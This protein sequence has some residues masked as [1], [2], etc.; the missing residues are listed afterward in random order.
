MEGSSV[1]LLGRQGSGKTSFIN[2]VIY[3]K[4]IPKK[5]ATYC[6]VHYK[7]YQ[8]TDTVC[9][10]KIEN[11]P[12]NVWNNTKAVIIVVDCRAATAVADI[13]RCAHVVKAES[14][15]STKKEHAVIPSILVINKV[16]GSA[17]RQ[18]SLQVAMIH[19]KQLKISTVIEVSVKEGKN[20]RLVLETI[21]LL[22]FSAKFSPTFF[23]KP[24]Q[25]T[26]LVGQ[27]SQ[28]DLCHQASQTAAMRCDICF[29]II[30]DKSPNAQPESQY[31]HLCVICVKLDSE[32]SRPR[33]IEI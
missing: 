18:L 28:L 5:A 20:L 3:P 22:V 10:T 9:I 25:L 14:Y 13:Q 26:L 11:K 1:T 12:Y 19:A 24:E 30:Y 2:A 4:I 15:K 23:Y 33:Y 16:D 8:F 31:S 27:L 7:N 32:K 21:E 29:S 17:A 6:S